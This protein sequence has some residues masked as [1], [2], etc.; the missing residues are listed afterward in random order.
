M[1]DPYGL[2]RFVQAQEPVMAQV[3][4]EL[5]AGRKRTHWM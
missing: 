3:L 2:D 4:A 1:V 5:A